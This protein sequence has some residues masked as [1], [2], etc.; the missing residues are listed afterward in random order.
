[1]L[2]GKTE[3]LD[4]A[5]ETKLTFTNLPEFLRILE[6]IVKGLPKEVQDKAANKVARDWVAAAKNKAAGIYEGKAAAS[7]SV[8]SDTDGSKITSHYPGF[9]GQEFGGGSRPE[10]QMFPPHRGKRGYFLYPAGRENSAKFQQ[11]WEAAIDNATK[12]WK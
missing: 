3:R 8:S 12:G 1:M 6:L 9:Y 5:G 4:V 7:L 11:V 2:P 10:T